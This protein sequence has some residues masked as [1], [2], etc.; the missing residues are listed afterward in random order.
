MSDLVMTCTK[1]RTLTVNRS[2][3][4]VNDRKSCITTLQSSGALANFSMSERDICALID[5]VT[6]M[7]Q[8][9]KGRFC[10]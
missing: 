1:K 9:S 3:V 10:I 2:T 7:V 4:H 8:L 5:V 6:D